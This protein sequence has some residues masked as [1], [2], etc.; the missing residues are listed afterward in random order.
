MNHL[1]ERQP[2]VNGRI[3][4]LYVLYVLSG[5]IGILAWTIGLVLATSLAFAVLITAFGLVEPASAQT[6]K[7][8]LWA[9]E[10]NGNDSKGGSH[11]ALQGGVSFAPG[12]VGQA[13]SFNGT[14]GYVKVPA[15]AN[16]PY[17][18]SPRTFMMWVYT[19]PTS[20]ARNQNTVFHFGGNGTSPSFQSG[21]TFGLDMDVHPNMEFYT[22]G[23]DIL[24]NAGVPQ[25]GWVH[26]AV[27]YD[28]GT[29]RI[30]TQGQQRAAQPMAL[31]TALTNLEIGA[32]I[33]SPAFGG[34]YFDGLIDEFM[35]FNR[36]LSASE[37]QTIYNAGMAKMQEVKVEFSPVNVTISPSTQPTPQTSQVPQ[38]TQTYTILEGPSI[39]PLPQKAP[40]A[41]WPPYFDGVNH[42]GPYAWVDSP[43]ALRNDPQLANAV[44]GGQE[45][46]NRL[47]VCRARLQDGTHT[48]KYFG[49]HC[50][51]GWGGKEVTLSQGYELLVNTQPQNAKFLSQTWVSPAGIDPNTTFRGGS[52]GNTQIRVSRASYMNGVHPGKEWE[53]KYNIGWGGKEVALAPYEVLVLGFDKAA[54]QAQQQTTYTHTITPPTQTYTITTTPSASPTAP[55]PLNIKV[56]ERK[57]LKNVLIV[58]DAVFPHKHMSI[59]SPSFQPV[60]D[61]RAGAKA[62]ME[63]EWVDMNFTSDPRA[64]FVREDIGNNQFRLRFLDTNLCLSTILNGGPVTL[65][66]RSD[67]PDQ[68]W[69]IEKVQNSDN[70]KLVSYNVTAPS[71]AAFNP[72]AP[73]SGMNVSTPNGKMVTK[74]DFYRP[75]IFDQFPTW[76][77]Q[78]DQP[79]GKP[80]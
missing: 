18:S 40:A 35:V 19:R 56:V 4:V 63:M 48:G 72:Y 1:T 47:L 73:I 5:R 58:R 31:N 17:G 67:G 14:N 33:G 30:Y 36:A 59:I 62:G 11:G 43:T 55:A 45:G 70:Y 57:F 13:F 16:L 34:L 80:E 39:V 37:I 15:S 51:I 49:G 42:M 60:V 78:D 26:V 65:Q 54:W 8:W 50:N 21:S 28:G 46:S 44:V 29:V 3:S 9:G 61:V 32:F 20:W 76:S 77:Y 12:V 23:N 22:W 41:D 7:E 68:I 10:G 27:T 25:E 69:G 75:L 53:G 2:F 74:K 71:G 6:P 64:W 24:F 52:V 66:P 79:T 38:T